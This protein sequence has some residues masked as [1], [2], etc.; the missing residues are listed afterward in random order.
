MVW[1]NENRRA[2]YAVRIT[3]EDASGVEM[4]PHLMELYAA[5]SAKL[6]SI[7]LPVN[8]PHYSD[9]DPVVRRLNTASRSTKA[10]MHLTRGASES[11]TSTM[12]NSF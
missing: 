7:N 9:C 6:L 1:I 8:I 2:T 5:L 3:F 12:P 4:T 11:A 10:V